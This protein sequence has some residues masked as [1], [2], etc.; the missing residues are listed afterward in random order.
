LILITKISTQFEV[1]IDLKAPIHTTHPLSPSIAGGLT[2]F[3][4]G[5][6]NYFK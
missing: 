1:I 5:W 2:I 6:I 4:Y 3:Q